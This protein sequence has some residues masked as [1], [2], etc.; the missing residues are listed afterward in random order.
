MLNPAAVLSTPRY[1]VPAV[2][3]VTNEFGVTG[4]FTGVPVVKV[5]VELLCVKGKS[6]AVQDNVVPAHAVVVAYTVG[7]G[8]VDVLVT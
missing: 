3:P 2:R 7:V 8:G 6:L 5:P 4:R 1:D